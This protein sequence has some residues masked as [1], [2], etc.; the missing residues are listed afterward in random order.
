MQ[1]N[2]TGVRVV[3]AF[4]RESYEIDRFDEKNNGFA[5]LWIKLGT[6]LAYY[7]GVGDFVSNLQ[8]LTVIVLGAVE[9]VAGNITLG[10]FIIFVTYNGMMVWPVRQLGRILSEMSKTSVSIERI[11]EI[12]RAEE[13]QDA[14]DSIEPP[15]NG[16]LVFEGV[17]FDYHG[18]NPV[19]KD[20]NF[21]VKAWEAPGAGNPP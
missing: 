12:L 13:E 14:P 18:I 21:T 15:M 9:A 5:R 17:N 4:G 1:E 8:V 6:L 19:L 16:D 11:D 10:E 3:R 7:W 20:I 2:Y